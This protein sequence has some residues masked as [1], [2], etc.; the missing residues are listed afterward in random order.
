MGFWEFS[1]VEVL[2]ASGIWKPKLHGKVL[3]QILKKE[4]RCNFLVQH[5]YKEYN[6]SY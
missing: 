2:R 4:D 5:F 3:Q 6:P 1:E